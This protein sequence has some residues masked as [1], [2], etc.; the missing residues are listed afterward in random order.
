MGPELGRR[1]RARLLSVG[2]FPTEQIP[3]DIVTN[4]ILGPS[5]RYSLSSFDAALQEELISHHLS[6]AAVHTAAMAELRPEP[7]LT[8]PPQYAVF[9]LSR[10]RLSLMN[11]NVDGLADL[12]CGNHRVINIHGTTLSAERRQELAWDTLIDGL[13][14]FPEIGPMRI[15]GLLLPQP[16]PIGIGLTLPYGSARRS[17]RGA[18]RLVLVGYAFGSMDD[19]VAYA[20]ITETIRLRRVEAAVITPSALDL[21]AQ[22]QED[23]KSTAVFAFPGYWHKLSKAIIL[24]PDR[25]RKKTCDHARLCIDCVEYLHEALLDAAE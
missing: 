5:R 10:F 8:P 4:R 9:S 6:P 3:R 20:L 19:H 23:S 18:A 7:S 14:E 21:S 24:S 25:P 17:L 13:Q 16:E 11:F 15:S 22:L 2:I 1:V 12:Y